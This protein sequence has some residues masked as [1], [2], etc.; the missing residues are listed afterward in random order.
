MKKGINVLYGFVV[1]LL[2]AA[3]Q[4]NSGNKIDSD[5]QT[6]ALDTASKSF[7]AEYESGNGTKSKSGKTHISVE[8]END[9]LII[10]AT[11]EDILELENGIV[12]F[13]FPSCP[14]CRNIIEPLLDF[15]KEENV[16][17][18]Y[19]NIAKIRDK[20]ELQQDSTTV[21]TTEKGT[22]GYR[23]LLKK[24][25]GIWDSYKGL[26]NDTVK[27]IYSPTVLFIK[28]NKAFEKKSGTVES[29]KDAYVKLTPEQHEELKQIYK[30]IYLRYKQ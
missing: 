23:S 26:K 19:L 20:K 18:H 10:Y 12:L 11:E 1:I 2:I 21:V 14:W 30:D 8:V 7:K 28:N 4:N 22:E 13:G 3:C 9:S 24:F 25:D 27:R 29:Q 6:T 17:I 5:Q 16:Q 15:A